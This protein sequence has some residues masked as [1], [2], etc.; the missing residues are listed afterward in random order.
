M[1]HDALLSAWRREEEEPFAGWDFAH[2]RGRM[3]EEQPPWSYAA[4][5]AEL[6]ERSTAVL[7]MGTGGGERL[8]ALRAHWPDKVAVTEG[9]A[10]NVALA[11]ERLAPLGV[12]VIDV[13]TSRQA[14]MPFADGEFDLVLN[15][16]SSLNAGE[17]ARILA[18]GGVF[19]TEQV[20]GRW[21]E[22]L[23]AVFGARPQWPDANLDHEAGRLREAGL[24]IDRAEGW[25]GAL[26]FTD[27]GAVVYYLH[28]VPWLVPGF[29]VATHA[30]AL[31]ALQSRLERGEPLA[32]AA[33]LYLLEARKA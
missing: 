21:A 20:D 6:L 7:D 22:D 9:Y 2:L 5:A 33:G 27:V 29:T 28:A 17:V 4:R 19:F 3:I 30:D 15:R 26:T 32:F 11:R 18:L 10:P 25:S 12:R 8:L 13:E 31:F 23:M 1:H 24:S 14:A 16:H